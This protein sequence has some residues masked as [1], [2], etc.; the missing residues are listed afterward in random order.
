MERGLVQRVEITPQFWSISLL[1]VV[2]PQACLVV[3]QLFAVRVLKSSSLKSMVRAARRDVYYRNTIP[4]IS[5]YHSNMTPC[6]T[7]P[8]T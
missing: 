6:N 1:L 2:R 3:E 5:I 8:E 4:Q 7:H